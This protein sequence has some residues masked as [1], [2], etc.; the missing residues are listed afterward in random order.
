MIPKYATRLGRVNG[1]SAL[2]AFPS[3]VW[4]DDPR[5]ESETYAPIPDGYQLIETVTD[6]VG[7]V[8]QQT[9]DSR[10][11]AWETVPAMARVEIEV[12]LSQ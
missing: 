12:P 2:I 7:L 6:Y 10:D 5:P 9:G 11:L 3:Y 8:N 4:S 1:T